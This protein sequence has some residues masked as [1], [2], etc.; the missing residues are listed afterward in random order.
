MR[1][2]T[3]ATAPLLEGSILDEQ[4][5]LEEKSLEDGVTRYR[6]LAADAVKRGDGAAL[7]PAERF[8]L[9][10]LAPLTENIRREQRRMRRGEPEKGANKWGGS[11]QML[12]P[13]VM[14]VLTMREV[15]GAC[16]SEPAGATLASV[17]YRVGRAAFAQ[18]HMDQMRKVKVS[19]T[20][21]RGDQYQTNVAA[22]I[23]SRLRRLTPAKANWWAGRVLDNPQRSR[24]VIAGLGGRLTWLLR[25]VAGCGEEGKPFE[26]AFTTR[27]IRR[28]KKTVR[29]LL[30]NDR[31]YD[32]IEN[33]MVR[34]ALMRPRYQPMLVQPYPWQPGTQGGY[35][36]IRT[37]FISKPTRT[38]KEAHARGDLSTVYA[39]LTAVH[40]TPWRINSRV[41][42]VQKQVWWSGGGEL[43]IPRRDKI[44]LPP[45]VDSTDE[46]IIRMAKRERARIY[47]QNIADKSIRKEW[48]MRLDVAERFE[49]QSMWFPHQLDFRGRVYP[50]PP[51]LN[52]QGDDTC[53]GMLEFADAK[54]APDRD[55]WLMIHA[56][57]C[58]GFDKASFE[59]RIAWTRAHLPEI[60]A[61]SEQPIV[62]E[63]WRKA[64]KPW[65]FLAASFAIFDATAAC[66]LPIQI[67][68]TCNGLQHYAALGRDTAGAALVNMIPGDRPAD[69]YTR[70]AE[71]VAAA[72][73]ADARDGHK[74][75][76]W[77]DGKVTR[78]V[79][80]QP[81]MTKVYGVTMVG[82]REQIEGQ[83]TW[84]QGRDLYTASAYLSGKVL[85]AIGDT[86]RAASDIMDWLR[87]TGHA[88]AKAGHAVAWTSPVG[89]PV[90][91]PY[92]NYKPTTIETD[93]GLLE[94]AV[95]D[96]DRPVAVAKQRDGLAPNFVHSVD[97]AHM[98]LTA[99]ACADAGVTFAAVH[100]CFLT[101]AA[102]ADRLSGIL[103]EQFVQ[104]HSRPLL[105]GLAAEFRIKFPGVT[106]DD[107]PP[108]GDY[109]LQQVLESPYFFS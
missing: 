22:Q 59:E 82:A 68:G 98:L 35:V 55:Y 99:K 4:I 63:F 108:P 26:L 91:Q 106:I 20:T 2:I 73:A 62:S 102:T 49:A 61:A 83:L 77:L 30:M 109:D 10:W 85:S 3:R 40:S 25:E 100:D 78:A 67:D 92:R 52:H 31:V 9:Y 57:N 34:R 8:L 36:K 88:I 69:I 95:N 97:A 13:D 24:E 80:K 71:K 14:A 74:E 17:V 48:L 47:D 51:H 19:L 65:Q 89:L 42:A 79:V 94:I 41:L 104:L 70:I 60:A 66:H 28:Q 93:F 54:S 6:Q 37:P 29:M 27:L 21:Q 32:V 76:Q 90:V 87:R 7:K 15:V 96:D 75:A 72:V 84:L 86:C 45:P 44:E 11:I 56:A 101:H 64:D 39:C 1:T 43:G 53:R 103:R 50:I 16:M 107:P 46:A 33:G 12:E 5:A 58:Y 23:E 105:A 81:V 18:I 38:Q